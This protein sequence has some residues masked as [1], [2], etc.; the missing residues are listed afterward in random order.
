MQQRRH[1][2][3]MLCVVILIAAA[4]FAFDWLRQVWEADLPVQ[5]PQVMP[6][7]QY[8]EYLDCMRW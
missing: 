7:H 4:S 2:L 5:T 3:A 6:D 8:L 1:P